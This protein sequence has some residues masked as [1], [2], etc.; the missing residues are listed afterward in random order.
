MPAQIPSRNYS[1]RGFTLLE[2]LLTTVL[3]SVGVLAIARAFSAGLLAYSDTQAVA[4]AVDIASAKMEEARAGNFSSITSSGPVADANFTDYLVTVNAAT[5]QNPM[6]INVTVNWEV[7][8]GQIGFT[9]ATM[10]ANYTAT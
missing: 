4:R 2:V 3:I 6:P 5:G 7:Q 10:I 9:L 8:G 1:R